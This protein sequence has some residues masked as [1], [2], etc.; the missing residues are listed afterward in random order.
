MSMGNN[1]R[2][3]AESFG[4]ARMM[5]TNRL[6]GRF[7]DRGVSKLGRNALRLTPPQSVRIAPAGQVSPPNGTG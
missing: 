6:S 4:D 5:P 7:A 2:K 1:S 3:T